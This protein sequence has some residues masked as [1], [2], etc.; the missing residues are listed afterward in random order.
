IEHEGRQR[1][2]EPR[3]PATQHDEA[4]ARELARARKIHLAQAFAQRDMILRR[5]TKLPRYAMGADKL[6]V[7]LVLAV[8]HVVERDVGYAREQP[9]DLGL[10]G[11]C[12]GFEP[13]SLILALGNAA[14][15]L[16]GV[17]TFRLHAADL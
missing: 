2:L 10:K 8:G 3:K 12:F 17:A 9:I 4:R 5:K 11:A 13:R 7:V 16:G 6:V 15:Q 14:H 1:S